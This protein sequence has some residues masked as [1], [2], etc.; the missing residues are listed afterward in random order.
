[1]NGHDGRSKGFMCCVT[2]VVTYFAYAR[3]TGR[4]LPTPFPLPTADL[5]TSAANRMLTMDLTPVRSRDSSIFPWT[6]FMPRR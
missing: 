4:P 3:Q 5:I 6:I 2:V 1:M